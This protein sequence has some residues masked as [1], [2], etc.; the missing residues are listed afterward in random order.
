MT[1][2]PP[3]ATFMPERESFIQCFDCFLIAHDLTEITMERKKGYFLSLCGPD[4]FSMARAL[5][6]P[7]S[8]HVVPWE[9]LLAKLKGHY[10]PALSCFA[11]RFAF[12]W[13]VQ[14]ETET[15]SQ[16]MV[17]LRQAAIYCEF[18]DLDEALLEQLIYGSR[19][20]R[21]QRHLLAKSELTLAIALDEARAVA[22]IQKCQAVLSPASATAVVNQQVA[23]EEDELGTADEVVRLKLTVNGRWKQATN[24]PQAGCLSCGGNHLRSA[25]RYKSATCRQNRSSCLRVPCQPASSSHWPSH[26]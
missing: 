14:K 8:V 24:L 10:A 12:R 25:C 26:E 9:V 13:C 11:R 3:F 22:V 18:Q 5:A 6:A 23:E 15:I 1:A 19:D 16:F 21:L 20:L 2:I 7:A 17:A 4:M